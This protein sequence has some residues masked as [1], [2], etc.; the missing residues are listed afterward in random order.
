MASAIWQREQTATI[1]AVLAAARAYVLF[2]SG[3]GTVKRS[4]KIAHETGG[5]PALSNDGR[6]GFSVTSLGDLNG[7]GRP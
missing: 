2:L 3:N 4:Q 1:R 7:D 6:F 5:G